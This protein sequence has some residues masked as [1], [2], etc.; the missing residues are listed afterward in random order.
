ME[1]SFLISSPPTVSHKFILSSRIKAFINNPKNSSYDSKEL[2]QNQP[3]LTDKIVKD[4][5]DTF[6]LHSM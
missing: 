3:Y 5:K 1:S 6:P 2:K 4:F